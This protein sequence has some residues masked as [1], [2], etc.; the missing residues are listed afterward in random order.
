M[1]FLCIFDIFEV[2]KEFI[3]YFFSNH[4]YFFIFC[5]CFYMHYVTFTL[6]CADVSSGYR[7]LNVQR[8]VQPCSKPLFLHPAK[9]PSVI[10]LIKYHGRQLLTGTKRR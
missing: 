5:P 8:A 6:P 7:C 1:N 9:L 4:A 3:S 2:F 10:F